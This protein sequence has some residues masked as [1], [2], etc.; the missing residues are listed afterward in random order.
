M[1]VKLLALSFLACNVSVGVA[2]KRRRFDASADLHGPDLAYVFHAEDH[3]KEIMAY[4]IQ[5]DWIEHGRCIHLLDMF[6][7]QGEMGNTFRNAGYTV[8]HFE[9]KAGGRKHN[10][11][12]RRGFFHA[13]D[14]ICS[15]VVSGLIVGGPP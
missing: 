3:I 14:V 2:G 10:I 11:L 8:E 7:G 13:L 4:V 9:V 12:T 5:F 1:L 6:A 15:M